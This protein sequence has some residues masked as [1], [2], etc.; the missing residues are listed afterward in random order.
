M[1]TLTFDRRVAGIPCQV[2]VLSFEG[3]Y[4]PAK[5]DADPGSCYPAEYPEIDWRLLDRRGYPAPWLEAK[6][7]D[8]ERDEIENQCFVLTKKD[9]YDDYDY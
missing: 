8:T 3:S 5:V 6:L 9:H 1:S 4:S 7:T 2:E